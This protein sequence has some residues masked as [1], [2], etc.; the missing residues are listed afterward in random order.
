MV[1]RIRPAPARSARSV[2]SRLLTATLVAGLLMVSGVVYTVVNGELRLPFTGVVFAFGDAAEESAPATAGGLRVPDGHVPVYANP[3]ALPA[4]T[5]ITR[6]H[7]LVAGD[8]FTLPVPAAAVA[9]SAL[10]RS[11]NPDLQRLIGRVLKQEKPALYAFAESD[12]LPKGTRP[13]PAAGIP[14]GMRGVWVDVREVTGL[15]DLCAGDLVDVVAAT[16]DTAPR[17]VDTGVLGNVTDTILKARIEAAA[18]R[19]QQARSSSS[20]VVARAARVIAPIRS[21]PA[22]GGAGAR[23]AGE[24]IDEVFLAMEPADVAR[25]GQALAQDVTLLAAPRS[26][27]PTDAPVEIADD[28][29]ADASEALRALLMGDGQ[30]APGSFGMVELIRGDTRETVTVPR[31]QGQR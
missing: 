10:Y 11:G 21:R 15:A 28:R 16:A 9:Q 18:N 13:G 2:S 4:Y 14:P 29:P 30:D 22:P 19:A 12:F 7:L 20:W 23:R 31:T 1:T 8:L 17:E 25:F 6:D 24:T 26:S 5:K 3:R 27:Q